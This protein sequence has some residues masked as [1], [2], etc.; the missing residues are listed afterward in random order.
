MDRTRGPV[1][2]LRGTDELLG[3]PVRDRPRITEAPEPVL[4]V[5]EVGDRLLGGDDHQ[6]V[7]APLLRLADREH[8]DP[9]RD[10]CHRSHV[11]VDLFRVME[12]VRRARDRAEM[13]EGSRNRVGRRQVIDQR[14]HEEGLG[15]DLADQ[16]RVPLVDARLQHP[17]VLGLRGDGGGCERQ[18]QRCDRAGGDE[19]PPALMP[20]GRD[21]AAA[22]AKNGTKRKSRH[23]SLPVGTAPA[24]RGWGIALRARHRRWLERFEGWG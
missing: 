13:I 21:V 14:R 19:R 18:R 7:L 20:G 9:R 3:L 11:A 15:R 24:R 4:V 12:N 5:V 6:D 16:P 8:L 1:D 10:R 17:L 2:G 22:T 23:E